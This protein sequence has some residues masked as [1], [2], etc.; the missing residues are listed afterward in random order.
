MDIKANRPMHTAAAC[1]FPCNMI[2]EMQLPRS[3]LGHCPELCHP[4]VPPTPTCNSS[5]RP[6]SAT[7]PCRT[8][9]YGQEEW[10]LS[11]CLSGCVPPHM[12]IEDSSPTLCDHLPIELRVDVLVWVPRLSW[13]FQWP[14]EGGEVENE[15]LVSGLPTAHDHGR[16]GEEM[17]P[18]LTVK[19]KTE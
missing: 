17:P 9:Q 10:S 11:R 7:H 18:F 14:E 13:G 4:A 12:G 1:D 16:R 15:R 5:G 2:N 8:A 3:S 6:R 19:E